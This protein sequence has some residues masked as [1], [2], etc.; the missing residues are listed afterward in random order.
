MVANLDSEALLDDQS[1]YCYYCWY[2]EGGWGNDALL[3]V[4]VMEVDA[5]QT[6]IWI[7]CHEDPCVDHTVGHSHWVCFVVRS[8]KRKRKKKK[9]HHSLKPSAVEDTLSKCKGERE[10]DEIAKG[11]EIE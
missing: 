9:N 11:N 10:R 5:Q 2:E 6:V 7:E 8:M 1:P 3:V 4:V